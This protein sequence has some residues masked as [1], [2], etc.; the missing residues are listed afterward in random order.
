M[1]QESRQ[2]A[3]YL[4][5]IFAV[6]MS[7]AALSYVF[8]IGKK[9]VHIEGSVE[10]YEEFQE[11]YNTCEKLNTDLCNMQEVPE[12]DKMFEQFTKAQRILALKEKLNEWVEKYNSNSKMYGRSIWKSKS[13]PYQLS[14]HDYE[15]Y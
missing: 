9:A 2:A 1:N 14:V 4:F 10:N 13:L 11:I 5:W 12:G 15:C 7:I 6:I 8:K 3:K